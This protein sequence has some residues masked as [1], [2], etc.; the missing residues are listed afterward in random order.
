MRRKF[1]EKIDNLHRQLVGLQAERDKALAKT[2]QNFAASHR[3][4]ANAGIKEKQQLLE[5]RQTY[6]NKMKGLVMEIH[7]LK[8]N[9]S[10][11]IANM[12]ST[13]NQQES[14]LRT[15]RANVETLKVEKKRMIK[16]MKQETERVKEQMAIQE[17]KISKLQRQQSE[18]P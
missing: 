11:T 10:R 14:L 6:E 4:D 9:Y 2:K 12:Q 3:T 16:R 5:T 17:R 15:L 1:D 13:K 8:R 18:L 7:D